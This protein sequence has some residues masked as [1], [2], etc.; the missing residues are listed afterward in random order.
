MD[1]RLGDLPGRFIGA[2]FPG[3]IVLD[4]DAA[5]HGWFVDPT[6]QESSEFANRSGQCRLADT[7]SPAQGRIDLLT[8]M[9]HELGHVLGLDDSN[10]GPDSSDVMAGLLQPGV[11]R[12]PWS[13][14]VDQFFAGE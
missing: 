10:A 5:G 8:V 9:A 2:A 3:V 4:A 11:R 7:D 6:P 13:E 12:L 14:A 1:V